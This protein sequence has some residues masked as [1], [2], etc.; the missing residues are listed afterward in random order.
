MKSYLLSKE[1]NSGLLD[2]DVPAIQ[3]E[4]R[5]VARKRIEEMYH[6]EGEAAKEEHVDQVCNRESPIVTV[7]G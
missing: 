6:Q 4:C 1:D 2:I 5:G 3:K 7:D